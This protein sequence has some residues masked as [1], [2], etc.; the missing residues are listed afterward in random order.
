MILR[1]LKREEGFALTEFALVLPLFIVLAAGVFYFGRITYAKIAADM[2]SYDCVRTA[3]EALDAGHGQAQGLRAAQDTIE[4]FYMGGAPPRVVVYAPNGWKR[5][6]QVRC[7]VSY[8]ISLKG[9]PL[10]H[11]LASSKPKFKVVSET[12]LRIE[13]YKSR[14]DY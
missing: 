11:L 6:R 3:A 13:E 10:I 12:A 9:V 2:A 5:G 1:G 7:R 4:G 8:G 14:W